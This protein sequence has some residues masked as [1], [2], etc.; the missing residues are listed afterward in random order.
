M[1]NRS[2]KAGSTISDHCTGAA[3][4]YKQ[5]HRP[6]NWRRSQRQHIEILRGKAMAEEKKFNAGTYDIRNESAANEHSDR[7]L[8][9]Y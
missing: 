6:R 8:C 5:N 2:T 4:T 7:Y 1:T 9:T 3:S